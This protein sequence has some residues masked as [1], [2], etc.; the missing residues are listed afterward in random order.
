MVEQMAVLDKSLIKIIGENEYYRILAV[1][2][3]EEMRERETELKQVE[4]LEMINEMLSEH[5][6]PPLTLSWIKGWWNKFE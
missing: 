1:M 4:A 5:D 2:E 3:L 6:R